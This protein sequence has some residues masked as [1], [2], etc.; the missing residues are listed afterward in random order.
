MTAVGGAEGNK[1]IPALACAHRME[2][3]EQTPRPQSY[4]GL[5]AIIASQ[6][7]QKLIELVVKV[8]QTNATVLITGESGVG[9]DIVAR[10]IHHRSRRPGSGGRRPRGI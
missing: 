2:S 3:E 10:L 1:K 5:S 4:L 6:P 9:K 7:M 8:A